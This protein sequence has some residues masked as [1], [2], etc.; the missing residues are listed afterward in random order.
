MAKKKSRK[1]SRKNDVFEKRVNDFSEEVEDFGERFGRRMERHG[2][3]MERWGKERENSF[4]Q[5]FGVVGP[6]ISSIIG[7]I[8]LSLLT[9]VISLI[10]SKIGAWILTDINLF[11]TS[12]IG[13]F[14]MLFLFFSYTSY[15]SKFHRRTYRLF[16]PVSIALGAA[17]C[18]WIAANALNT[19]NV[20]MGNPFLSSLAFYMNQSL[21][22]VFWLFLCVGYLVLAI[23]I[24]TE[25]TIW[26]P[27]ERAEKPAAHKAQKTEAGIRRLYRSGSD[28][29]LGGVCGGIAEYFGIDPVIIRLLW[30]IFTLAWGFGV[31]L[32]IICWIVIPRNPNQKWK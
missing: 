17:V 18:F 15:F 9:W 31:L 22:L 13:I 7:I 4:Q 12:N 5:T 8:L 14:F 11:L 16:S 19:V 29:I 32:Y 26:K 30:V 25:K 27:E 1:V 10:N 6:L 2:R 3:N 28:R 20:S 21:F 23:I 24:A